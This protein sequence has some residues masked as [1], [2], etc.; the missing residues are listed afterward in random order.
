MVGANMGPS[1]ATSAGLLATSEANTWRNSAVGKIWAKPAA[2][3]IA[4]R[5]GSTIQISNRNRSRRR[6]RRISAP[7]PVNPFIF[8]AYC[9]LPEAH[10]GA[11]IDPLA[12]AEYR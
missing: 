1:S 6:I 10:S 7:V 9:P 8:M 4:R 2:V 5:A 12:W 11:R 3:T